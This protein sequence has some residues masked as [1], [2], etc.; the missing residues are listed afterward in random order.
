MKNM[1]MEVMV[2]IPKGSRNK[3]EFDKMR[4]LI[5]FD[6]MLFSAVHY[7]SDYGFIPNTLASDG[8]PLDALV[9]VW[10]PT[11]PGCLI[12]AKPIGL[13]QMEDEKGEDDKILCVPVNDPLWNHI[14]SLRDVPPHLLKEIEHFFSVYK[15][16]EEKKVE[17][18]GWKN[19]ARALKV[20]KEA[21]Q[22]YD[23][24]IHC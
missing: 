5:R 18:R 13:F 14:S 19:K 8:D 20:I 3:Y 12:E 11:F 16:L 17:I 15:A 9:L 6:R 4:N 22:R 2:E 21:K 24:E 23:N 7:P 1:V 10:E